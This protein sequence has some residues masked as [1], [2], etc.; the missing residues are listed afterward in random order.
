ML[1]R[2]TAIKLLPPD[3]AGEVEPASLRAR[4]AAH[5]AA[6]AIPNTVAIY[7]YGR[8]PDGIFY[9]AMEYLDGINLEELVRRDGP[10]PAGRVDPHPRRR[11]AARSRK[12]TS[13]AS[14]TATSSRPTSSS[15]SAAAS[16][17]SRRSSTSASSRSSRRRRRAATMTTAHR[18]HRH[19]ALH[20]ARGDDRRPTRSMRAAT[21]TRSARSA[22]SC[23]PASR[24]SKPASMAE[25]FGHHLHT[26]PL[27]PSQR[28]TNPI[29]AE[30]ERI[31]LACLSKN[32]DGTAAERPGAAERARTAPDRTHRGARTTRS[33]G[34]GSSAPR[35]R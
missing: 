26:T 13:A 19:A 14:S 21:S 17:T 2:P 1:R 18:A 33:G 5:G 29:P 27:P 16:P 23:S 24:C 10:Q 6:H 15:A 7:D 31:I 3:R 9:Y 20:G 32:V 35:N 8:T 12:R 4:G 25:A 28:T 22:T 30:L 11:S 34:G